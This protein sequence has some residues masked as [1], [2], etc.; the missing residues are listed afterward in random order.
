MTGKDGQPT[1]SGPAAGPARNQ[2]MLQQ[3][4]PSGVAAFP[5]WPGTADMVRR[6]RGARLG[7]WMPYGS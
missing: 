5:G 2:R 7:I 1:D 3:G 6:A 4:M